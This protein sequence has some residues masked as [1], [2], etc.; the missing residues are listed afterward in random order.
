[1]KFYDKSVQC[2]LSKN[3]KKSKV[4]EKHLQN[5]DLP[6]LL[7]K[8]IIIFKRGIFL[9]CNKIR[10]FLNFYLSKVTFNIMPYV[11]GDCIHAVESNFC[12]IKT[13]WIDT[14]LD[15]PKIF[16]IDCIYSIIKTNL[17]S[18]SNGLII[19]NWMT[20]EQKIGILTINGVVPVAE[21]DRNYELL[22]R[23]E[24]KKN[25]FNF[26]IKIN[27]NESNLDEIRQNSVHMT[28]FL[29]KKIKNNLNQ[30][31]KFKDKHQLN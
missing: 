14:K 20:V 29:A 3:P 21:A 2:L 23:G 15:D 24:N 22:I 12:G 25:L 18:S 19:P 26:W 4:I 11:H 8:M 6:E 27:Q 1:M 5:K 7:I 9:D 28:Q 17:F 10:M 31:L 30:T 16:G 13:H